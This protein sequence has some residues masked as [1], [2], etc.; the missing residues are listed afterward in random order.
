MAT[1][2]KY[3]VRDLYKAMGRYWVGDDEFEYPLDPN[4]RYSPN[5]VAL[6]RE[7]YRFRMQ[8][9]EVLIEDCRAANIPIPRRRAVG[10]PTDTPAMLQKAL[11]RFRE[12]V[13]RMQQ[14]LQR[15]SFRLTA[16]ER[17]EDGLMDEARSYMA[18]AN[19]QDF[20]S[21]I[22]MSDEDETS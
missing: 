14:R 13:N 12:E 18:W 7:E 3:R 22:E 17:A 1:P 11:H 15:H 8:T 6:M 4:L 19:Q 20:R 2:G 10:M 9:S 5:N 16:V 21:D